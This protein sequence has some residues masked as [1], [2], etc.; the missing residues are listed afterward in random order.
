MKTEQTEN[1]TQYFFLFFPRFLIT[2]KVESF[3]FSHILSSLFK[4]W[5]NQKIITI[6][7]NSEFAIDFKKDSNKQ[8]MGRCGGG[9]W[10]ILER[11]FFVWLLA[12]EWTFFLAIRVISKWWVREA[13]AFWTAFRNFFKN[14]YFSGNFRKPHHS[15]NNFF[16]NIRMNS[17]TKVHNRNQT[18]PRFS[19]DWKTNK[20]VEI[21]FNR[22]SFF[23][24]R[25]R[26]ETSECWSWVFNCRLFKFVN[27]W[28]HP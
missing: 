19:S 2:K 9:S 25:N 23:V 11:F 14:F 5:V 24:V 4:S 15:S 17:F 1:S 20:K 3:L 8:M 21:N 28:G 16:A 12:V 7:E 22:V 27:N 10:K 26:F 6:T 13:G 18:N